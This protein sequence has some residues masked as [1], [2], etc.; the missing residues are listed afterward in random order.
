MNDQY[1]TPPRGEDS[2]GPPIRW[3]TQKSADHAP[4]DTAA[5]TTTL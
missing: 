4:I 2:F 1:L 3:H 5:Q